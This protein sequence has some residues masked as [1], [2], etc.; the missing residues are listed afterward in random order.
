MSGQAESDRR[1]FTRYPM[2]T[3]VEF[4]HGPSRRNY[5]ARSVD[6]SRGGMLMFVPATTPVAPGQPIRV[7][8]GGYSQPELHTLSNKPVEGTIV[9][10]DRGGMLEAGHL[11]VGVR[12][13][14][15]VA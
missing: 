4:F 11:P 14:Q 10:V 6:V 8:L 12:F 5:P 1:Q 3:T 9:R 2:A 13:A 15:P 7:T